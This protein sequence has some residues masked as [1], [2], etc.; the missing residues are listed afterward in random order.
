ME[1]GLQRRLRQIASHHVARD[2]LE[3]S[4]F[5]GALFFACR[6]GIRLAFHHYASPFWIP[7]S[8]LLC[9]LLWAQPRRWPLLLAATLP[10][11]LWAILP[12]AI[13][14]WAIVAAW[15]ADSATAAL[16]ATLVRWVLPRPFRFN[17]IREFGSFCLIAVLFASAASASFGAIVQTGLGLHYWSS[18][19]HWFWGDVVGTL[20]IAPVLVY[21]VLSPP[22]YRSISVPQRLEAVLLLCG[23][24]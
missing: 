23:L 14:V 4:F 21:W 12:S 19:E 3:F 9:A 15:A 17:T 16:T 5:L 6:Y 2:I 10:I 1:E 8:V 22:D 24:L 7:S 13:P 20:V 11:R 18:W